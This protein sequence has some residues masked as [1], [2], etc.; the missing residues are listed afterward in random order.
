MKINKEELWTFSIRSRRQRFTMTF[1]QENYPFIKDVYIMRQTKMIE[2]MENVEKAIS[3]IMADKVYTSAEFKRERDNFHV[4]ILSLHNKNAV[5]SF[6]SLRLPFCQLMHFPLQFPS[7]FSFP[8]WWESVALSKRCPT[9]EKKFAT[10]V[11]TVATLV[12]YCRNYTWK[13]E[14]NY[15]TILFIH[16]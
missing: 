15:Y 16:F 13:Y 2:W 11:T 4:R 1:W 3:R 10:N 5:S 9:V 8:F 14:L 6:Q 12:K 7:S